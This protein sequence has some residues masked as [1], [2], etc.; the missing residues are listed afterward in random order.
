MTTC[1]LPLRV[2]DASR[3]WTVSAAPFCGPAHGSRTARAR[4]RAAALVLRGRELGPGA[5][6]AARAALHALGVHY[7]R[8]ARGAA[9]A[10]FPALRSVR[11][12]ALAAHCRSCATPSVRTSTSPPTAATARPRTRSRR[13]RRSLLGHGGQHL[14]HRRRRP[15]H[16]RGSTVRA[17]RRTRAARTRGSGR[18][19]RVGEADDHLH[20]DLGYTIACPHAAETQVDR[21]TTQQSICTAEP[22][23]DK[24]QPDATPRQRGC[25]SPPS[26]W[27]RSSCCSWTTSTSARTTCSASPRAFIRAPLMHRR[28]TSYHLPTAARSTSIP[29]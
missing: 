12:H 10:C 20:I 22:T 28:G 7:R 9:A 6:D 18:T 1:A 23:M 14:P 2:V 15:R 16:G 13:T 26:A 8:R 24:K 4:P 25:S 27:S 21:M 29:A 3:C 11:R 19:A 17:R 5:R